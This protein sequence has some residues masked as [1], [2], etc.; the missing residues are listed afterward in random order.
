MARTAAAPS[1]GLVG[2][3]MLGTVRYLRA[4]LEASV[5]IRAGGRELPQKAESEGWPRTAAKPRVS[6]LNSADLEHQIGRKQLLL[7]TEGC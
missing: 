4:D 6:S 2:G 5:P 1:A 7:T 3:K